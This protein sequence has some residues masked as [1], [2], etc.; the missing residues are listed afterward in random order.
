LVVE[1]A[2][3]SGALITAD[4]ALEQGREVFVIP[5]KIDS[6]N[7]YGANEL[8][9][10]GARLVTSKEDILEGLYLPLAEKTVKKEKSFTAPE[11]EGSR[12][13]GLISDEPLY[14]DEII[15][16]TNLGVQ[17]ISLELLRLQIKKLI[18]QLPGKQYVRSHY[19]RN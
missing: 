8:I 2:R 6:E 15:E 1:A 9:K 16:K 18:R 12:L 3:N 7:S 10:Q 11:N 5:G 14:F 19:A 17:E 4:F 13:Y